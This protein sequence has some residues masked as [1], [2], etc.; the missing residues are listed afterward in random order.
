[1]GFAQQS[2]YC[3]RVRGW[4][5]KPEKLTRKRCPFLVRK[6]RLLKATE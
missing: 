4:Q 5:V 1:M 3:R 2:D 6:R